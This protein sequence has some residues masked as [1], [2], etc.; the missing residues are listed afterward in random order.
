VRVSVKMPGSN[1]RTKRKISRSLVSRSVVSRESPPLFAFPDGTARP[2]PDA[3]LSGPGSF[4]RVDPPKLFCTVPKSVPPD[5]WHTGGE[6]FDDFGGRSN[7]YPAANR[8]PAASAPSQQAW[9]PSMKCTPVSTPR[10]SAFTW[11]LPQREL[12]WWRKWR[13]QGSTSRTSH[14]HCIFPDARRAVG[15]NPWN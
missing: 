1:R 9:S 7:G 6:A 12:P 10:G 14:N 15:G 13:S 5:G 4:F 8:A 3:H 2:G 11:H